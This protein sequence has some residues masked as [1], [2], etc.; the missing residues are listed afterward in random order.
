MDPGTGR[1]SG[2]LGLAVLVAT[3]AA[4]LLVPVAQ[5]AAETLKVNIAGSGSGEVLSLGYEPGTPAIEC[6]GPPASG[7]CEN[8]FEGFVSIGAVPAPGSKFVSWSFTKGVAAAFCDGSVEEKEFAEEYDKENGE[9]GLEGACFAEGGTVEITAT[10]TKENPNLKLTIEEGSGTVVSSPAGLEC[11][12]V[13]VKSCEAKLPVGKV[14]LTASPAP[15]YLFKG[16]KGCETGGVNGRQCT[17]TV[18]EVE[19]PTMVGVK[20]VKAWKLDASKSIPNGIFSTSPG[21]VNCGFGCNSSSALYKEVALTL[22][23]KPAKHFHF[24]EFTSGTGS[25]TVCNGV[26]T[27]TCAIP[28]ITEDSAIKEVYAEDAK[29]TLT[30]KKEGGGQGFIKTKPTSINCGYTCTAAKGEFYANETAE[31]TVTLNKGTTSVT[32]V[33]GAGGCTTGSKVLTCTVPMSSSAELVAK[34]D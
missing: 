18:D 7:T 13:A 8:T 16:W 24:V 27:E 14:T 32:W 3:V 26:K 6:S 33:K 12:G 17:V 28:T 23:T 2:R 5:A 31:V 21:G 29:N 34:L 15:G 22:K 9:I 25:A 1:S 4:F 30:L 20:F 10:F 19:P 11:S